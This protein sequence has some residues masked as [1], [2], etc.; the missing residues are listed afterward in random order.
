MINWITL[1]IS[2]TDKNKVDLVMF[3]IIFSR[4]ENETMHLKDAFIGPYGLWWWQLS[5]VHLS[6]LFC[7]ISFI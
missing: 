5:Y 1:W 6:Q 4:E 7:H 3:D 2:E